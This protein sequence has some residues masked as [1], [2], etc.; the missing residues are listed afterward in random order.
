[1]SSRREEILRAIGQAALLLDRFPIGNRTG[2]DI[3]GA[4][5]ALEIPVLFRPLDGLWGAA[6]SVDQELKGILVTSKLDLPVQRFTLAHELGHI[7]LGHRSSFDEAGSIGFS[8]RLGSKRRS[9]PEI[10]A[11]TFASEVLGAKQ[12]MLNL[13]RR[14]GWD[15]QALRRRDTVYQLSLRLG[16]SFVAACWALAA[17]RAVS[18]EVARTLA[19]NKPKDIKKT[20]VPPA[21]LENPWASAWR[22]TRADSGSLLEAGPDDVFAVQLQDY[23]SAGYLW[24]LV[25]PEPAVTIVDEIPAELDNQESYSQ[26][27]ARTI[28]LRLRSPGTHSLTFLHKR[29]WSGESQ[30]KID[31][32]VDNHGKEAAGLPRRVRDAALADVA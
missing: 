5:A 24:E 17:Q 6:L 3:L 21:L 14:Q 13:A 19:L 22:I 32:A 16:V 1:M 30:E 12:L 25:D 8:G 31:I 7:L 11:D 20:I 10:A 28:F 15:S 29:R 26:P 27:V 4:I 23:A 9:T 18:E 2:F